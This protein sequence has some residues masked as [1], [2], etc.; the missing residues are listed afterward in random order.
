VLFIALAIPRICEVIRVLIANPAASSLAEL[1]FLPVDKRSMAWVML[2]LLERI[3]SCAA[4]AFTFVL[5]TDMLKLLKGDLTENFQE[6]FLD[7]Q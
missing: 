1:I 4:N 7:E 6:L 5:I 3:D 2:R